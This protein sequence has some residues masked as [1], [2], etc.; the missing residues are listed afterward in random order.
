MASSCGT[1]TERTTR[2]SH[3]VGDEVA[4]AVERMR[5]VRQRV[6]ER[7]EAIPMPTASEPTRARERS[8]LLERVK[9][10]IQDAGQKG[11]RLSA[12][13]E[14]VSRSA[15]RLVRRL[16]EEVRELAGMVVRLSPPDLPMVEPAELGS[17]EPPSSPESSGGSMRDDE[18]GGRPPELKL[19]GQEHLLPGAIPRDAGR[20]TTGDHNVSH[21]GGA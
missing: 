18:P 16:E 13:G 6:A 17:S 9:E 8:R 3:E 7:L 14:S 5:T 12:A 21:E 1:A 20:R 11:E 15:E 2:L 19:M 10:M 4:S